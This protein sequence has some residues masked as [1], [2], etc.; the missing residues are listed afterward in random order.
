MDPPVLSVTSPAR[1][2]VDLAHAVAPDDLARAA[3]EARFRGLFHLPSVL[4]VLERRRS[5]ALRELL[6]N[7]GP[8]QSPLEDR[9]LRICRRHGLPTPVTQRHITGS[10]VDFVWPAHRVVVETDGDEAHGTPAAF[11]QDRTATNRM[12]LAGYIVLRFTHA[13]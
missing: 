12:Q 5:S 6:A 8:T 11:Q 7:L 1:T 4:V 13:P 9:L 3:R 10:R 2:L